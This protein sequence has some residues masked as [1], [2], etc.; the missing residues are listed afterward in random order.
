[1]TDHSWQC[2][3]MPNET[4][5]PNKRLSEYALLNQYPEDWSKLRPGDNWE[6]ARV[7]SAQKGFTLIHYQTA[8]V[9]LAFPQIQTQ[10]PT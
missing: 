6:Q 2:Y 4:V 8:I 5:Y 10:G 7:L 9:T 1:M 3:F